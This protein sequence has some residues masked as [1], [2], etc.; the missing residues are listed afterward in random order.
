MLLL[1]L[2]TKERR[3]KEG[4]KEERDLKERRLYK[5]R[6]RERGK[7]RKERERE[8]EKEG[9]GA[10]S[11]LALNQIQGISSMS[12]TQQ[13]QSEP[14]EEQRT[15]AVHLLRCIIHHALFYFNLSEFKGLRIKIYIMNMYK[16]IHLKYE[17][18]NNFRETRG[19]RQGKGRERETGKISSLSKKETAGS[20]K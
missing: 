5:E 7:E 14:S 20:R 10:P 6:E 1:S 11:T 17:T 4:R 19:K 12:L 16:N 3:R 9:G 15:A 2:G 13:E 18:T 8:R